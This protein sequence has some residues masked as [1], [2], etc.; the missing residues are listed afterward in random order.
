MDLNIIDNSVKYNEILT[1]ISVNL[2]NALTTFGSSSKQYQTVLEILKDCLRNIESD[3]K[4]SSLSLDP[5]T[6]SL[7]MGFLEIGK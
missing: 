5:D 3:R 1:Q 6:L 4:Q 2:N 7:A